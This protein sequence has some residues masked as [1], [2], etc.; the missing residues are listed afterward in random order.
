MGLRGPPAGTFDSSPRRP[1]NP[2]LSVI[3]QEDSARIPPP[4]PGR[5]AVVLPDSFSN[6]SRILPPFAIARKARREYPN[7]EHCRC[8]CQ[9]RFE[10]VLVIR[11]TVRLRP[12]YSGGIPRALLN[13]AKHFAARSIPIESAT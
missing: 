2:M 5:M 12:W 8:G 7:P 10:S 9:E 1:E 6:F 3:P 13:C 11:R 4:Y